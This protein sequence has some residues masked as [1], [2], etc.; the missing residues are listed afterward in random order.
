MH[1]ASINNLN[2]FYRLFYPMCIWVDV[3]FILLLQTMIQK[4]N[5]WRKQWIKVYRQ[6]MLLPATGLGLLYLEQ[7]TL[8]IYMLM[9]WKWPLSFCLS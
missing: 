5:G 3:F 2:H 6:D 4:A 7:F 1:H 8:E 9:W